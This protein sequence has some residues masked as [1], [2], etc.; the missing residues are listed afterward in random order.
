MTI[1][2]EAEGSAC[3]KVLYRYG[4]KGASLNEEGNEDTSEKAVDDTR[5]D[6]CPIPA[7]PYFVI[8]FPLNATSIDKFNIICEVAFLVLYGVGRCC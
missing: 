8:D 7:N 5:N 3:G 2:H 6:F 4:V 1:Y